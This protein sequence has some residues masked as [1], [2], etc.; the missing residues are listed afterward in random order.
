MIT[1]ATTTVTVQ[2]GSE[3]EPGEGITWTTGARHVRAH[4]STP[5]GSELARP[6]GGMTTITATALLDPCTV[7]HTDRLVDDQT[8]EVWQVE[9][10]RTR[11]G[12]GLD[13]VEAGVKRVEGAA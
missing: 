2:T 4:F 7:S 10:C 8:G 1:L 6:G 11:R 13:H 3:D 9:W 12:L 5:S